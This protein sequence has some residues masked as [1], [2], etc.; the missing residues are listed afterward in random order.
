VAYGAVARQG[1]AAAPKARLCESILVVEDSYPNQLLITKVLERECYMVNLAENGKQ[2]LA[3]MEKNHYDLVLMDISMPVMD[4]LDATRAIRA[5][6]GP[7]SRTIIIA[8]TAHAIE[9]NRARCLEA[10]MDDYLTKPVDVTQLLDCIGRWLDGIGERRKKPREQRRELA[11]DPEALP[12]FKSAVLD[13]LVADTSGDVV[14]RIVD[15][16]LQDAVASLPNLERHLSEGEM[17]ALRFGA[18]SLKGAAGSC[19]GLRLQSEFKELEFAARAEDSAAASAAL[20]RVLAD[21]QPTR[22]ELEAYLER[23][24]PE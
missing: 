3:A 15:L 21:W 24:R 2:A 14:I 12:V 11:A 5:L 18:H 7:D 8:L 17:E 9:E 16:F 20:E 22:A 23:L 6:E 19:G 4:G 1:S 13:K 10:G